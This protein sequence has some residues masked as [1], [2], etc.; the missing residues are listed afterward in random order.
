[1]DLHRKLDLSIYYWLVDQV[2]SAITVVDGF[3][4][5]E[6]VLPTV[7]ITSLDLT[8]MPFELGG[9]DLNHDMWRI[10]VFAKNVA[11][12][13]ELAYL[14]FEALQCN[15]P[16]YDYAVGFPPTTIP[17]IGLLVVERR[18]LRPIYVFEDLVDKLYWRTSITFF[19][20]YEQE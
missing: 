8:A 9:N 18:T 10:D 6:L 2:P 16:V 20:H 19:S 12:R 4:K 7:S 13:D 15:I 11:Q 17:R 14:L 3:P 1:M 5:A